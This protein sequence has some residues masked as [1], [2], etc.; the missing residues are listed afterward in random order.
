MQIVLLFVVS[1]ANIYFF[2]LLSCQGHF[3]FMHTL[4]VGACLS[5]LETKL[6]ISQFK[7]KKEEEC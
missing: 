4:F 2:L 5:V 7:K 3:M 6:K 1:C